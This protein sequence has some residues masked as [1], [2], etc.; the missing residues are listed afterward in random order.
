MIADRKV[1]AVIAPSRSRCSVCLESVRRLP[2][3]KRLLIGQLWNSALV[4][5]YGKLEERTS[6]FLLLLGE[7][8]QVFHDSCAGHSP[9]NC[10]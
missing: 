10:E 8:L 3:V 9:S 6:I 7:V 2:H 4:C 1:L 5:R